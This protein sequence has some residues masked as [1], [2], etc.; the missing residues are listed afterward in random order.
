MSVFHSGKRKAHR[1]IPELDGLWWGLPRGIREFVDFS[2]PIV[3]G[4][5]YSNWSTA[6]PNSLS[7][8][9]WKVSGA[10]V[11]GAHPYAA[12]VGKA[13]AEARMRV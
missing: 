4:G 9:L 11:P 5:T 12:D 8:M 1:I 6:I 7:R 2:V 13:I 10:L 3:C